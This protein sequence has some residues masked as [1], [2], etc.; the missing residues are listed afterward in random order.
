MNEKQ[1]PK[2]ISTSF[3]RLLDCP[4]PIIAGPMFLVS[5]EELVIAVSEAGGLGAMPSLNWRTP[6]RFREA[7][8]AVKARTRKPFAVNLIVNQAN[9]RQHADLAICAEEKVPLV[10]T[11]LG[12]PKE[13]IRRMHEAGGK[14]FCDVTTLDYARKVEALGA[15]GVIAVSA[16]AGGHA[17]PISP[18]V[19]IPYLKRHLRIPIIAAGGVATGEQ[20]AALL[21]LGA[22][23]VQV[24]TRFIATEEAK[25]DPAYKDAILRSEPEDIVMTLR[26]SGTPAAVIRTPY[27][28]RVGLDLNPIEKLLYRFPQT[29]KAMKMLRY[30]LGSRALEKAAHQTTWKE[31]WSA[32]QGVGLIDDL[33]PAGDLVRSLMR[34]CRDTLS[35]GY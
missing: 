34:E 32:G 5:D 24:G 31:V 10:I 35:H 17:G 13:A 3:T 33:R 2:P 21:L 1:A 28:E 26:I 19:L 22:A 6:E 11:S 25:V 14:V 20:I 27:I 18:L 23:G 8:R 15:D 12:N 29:K 7:V 9:P 4:Y 30:H 16:G